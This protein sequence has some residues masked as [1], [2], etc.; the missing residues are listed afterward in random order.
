MRYETLGLSLLATCLLAFPVLAQSAEGGDG[1]HRRD[2]AGRPRM[3]EIR[4]RMIAEFDKDGDGG[5]NEEEREAIR[6]RD[7]RASRP[8]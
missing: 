3:V 1:E 4:E 8:P 2:T 6:E 7:A 5:L